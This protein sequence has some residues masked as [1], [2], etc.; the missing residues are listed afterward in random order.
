[1]VALRARCGS[2]GIGAVFP[3]AGALAGPCSSIPSRQ[4][5][6][7][8]LAQAR[9][10]CPQPALLLTAARAAPALA[11]HWARGVLV[12]WLPA[13]DWLRLTGLLHSCGR[14]AVLPRVS[15]FLPRPA[16]GSLQGGS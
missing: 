11:V 12:A 9:Q 5:A 15:A 3:A 1:M 4:P 8:R 16:P 2:A 10:S 7:S 6:S 13:G 14:S